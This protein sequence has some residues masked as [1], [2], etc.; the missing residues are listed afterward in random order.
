M[1]NRHTHPNLRNSHIHPIPEFDLNNHVPYVSPII[2]SH[3]GLGYDPMQ[4]IP[5]ESE[6]QTTIMIPH[7]TKAYPL[8]G[9]LT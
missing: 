6:S 1:T 5:H 7:T 4:S 3:H 2:N 8:K 9:M